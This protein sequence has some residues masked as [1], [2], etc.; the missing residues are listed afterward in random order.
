MQTTITY[1]LN[2]FYLFQS[3]RSFVR[4]LVRGIN[5]GHLIGR[6]NDI[7]TN[8]A[9]LA[10]CMCLAASH[11]LDAPRSSVWVSQA[12]RALVQKF[13]VM[14][15]C[16]GTAL[17]IGMWVFLFSYLGTLAV[18]VLGS[19]KPL[20]CGE[21]SY[22]VESLLCLGTALLAKER[23]DQAILLTWCRCS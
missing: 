5:N 15:W 9:A 10:V 8:M 12:R 16:E 22:W 19:F 14:V 18:S 3:V 20:L 21:V 2:I 11:L 6:R 7:T 23:H 1:I 13:T 4:L 17:A